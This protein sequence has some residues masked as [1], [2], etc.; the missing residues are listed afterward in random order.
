MIAALLVLAQPIE[1]IEEFTWTPTTFS[2]YATRYDGRRAAN[3]KRYDHKGLTAASTAH[4]FGTVLELRYKGRTVTVTVTDRMDRK[5]GRVRIDLSGG[6]FKALH[7]AYDMTDRTGT[8]LKGE[9]RE[10]KE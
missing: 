1:N 7:P 2:V 3:G 6:A 10:V 4:K 8:L 9:W 5:L